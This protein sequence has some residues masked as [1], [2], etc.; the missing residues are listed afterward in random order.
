MPFSIRK[1]LLNERNARPIE[2][3]LDKLVQFLNE[4]YGRT[5]R[6]DSRLAYKWAAGRSSVSMENV[7]KEIDQMFFLFESTDFTEVSRRIVSSVIDDMYNQYGLD[8]KTSSILAKRYMVP[9]TKAYYD[10]RGIF[11][12][13]EYDEEIECEEEERV[14]EEENVDSNNET[15]A[16]SPSTLNQESSPTKTAVT[17]QIEPQATIE[18]PNPI[19]ESPTTHEMEIKKNIEIYV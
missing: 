10:R 18:V 8:R 3:N 15:P 5:L 14:E 12:N 1:K 4:K 19:V 2:Q 7:A 17:E 13:H 11:C 6:D 9:A 16:E